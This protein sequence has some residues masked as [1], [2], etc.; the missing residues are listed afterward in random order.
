MPLVTSLAPIASNFSFFVT[1]A[2]S[3]Q[4]IKN[5]HG[6]IEAQVVSIASRMGW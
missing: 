3:S 4:A 1:D 5:Y 6:F 2:A